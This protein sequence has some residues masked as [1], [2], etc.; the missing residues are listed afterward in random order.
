[1]RHKKPIRQSSNAGEEQVAIFNGFVL[2]VVFR[3]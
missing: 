3:M 1:L 2:K